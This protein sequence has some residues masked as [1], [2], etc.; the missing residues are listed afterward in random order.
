VYSS[1]ELVH[2]LWVEG[3]FDDFRNSSKVI[4]KSRCRI[5]YRELL[6]ENFA[7]LEKTMME[8]TNKERTKSEAVEQKK[9][10]LNVQLVWGCDAWNATPEAAG[11]QLVADL[12]GLLAAGGSVQVRVTGMDGEEHILEVTATRRQSRLGGL[13]PIRLMAVARYRVQ[14][15]VAIPHCCSPAAAL[16]VSF[17]EG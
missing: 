5:S 6:N 15:L 1:K 3:K 7:T 9:P 16:A 12:F 4:L 8:S 17:C 14:V 11:R 13:G 10:W 2:K